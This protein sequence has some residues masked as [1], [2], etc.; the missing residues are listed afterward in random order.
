MIINNSHRTQ[1]RKIFISFFKKLLVLFFHSI[2]DSLFFCFFDGT[3]KMNEQKLVFFFVLLFFSTYIYIYLSKLFDRITEV[4]LC[5]KCACDTDLW[6]F[7]QIQRAVFSTI[8]IALMCKSR[9][10]HK[11]YRRNLFLF[12]SI[13]RW[14]H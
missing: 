4:F 1:Q 8:I 2:N 7:L 14:K 10:V 5:N 13:S 11:Y 3:K 9:N 6:C 12:C